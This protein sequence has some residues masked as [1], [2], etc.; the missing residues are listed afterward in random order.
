M[1]CPK[2]GIQN[3]D[4]GRFCR[5]CGTDLG[6]VSQALSGKLPTAP[7][8]RRNK[9]KSLESSITKIFTGI[10]FIVAA[11]VLGLTGVAG[12]KFWW[13]WL[14]IPAFGSLGSGV[15]EYI[16]HR[17]YE[18]SE[19]LPPAPERTQMAEDYRSPGLNS[20]PAAAELSSDPRYRTGDLV[21]PSVT[22]HTTKLLQLE[23]EGETRTLPPT[24]QR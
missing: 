2:C 21:P 1:F 5:S 19:E 10:A 12:G 11:A 4:N 20:A 22:D 13:F 3:P 18:A 16:S 7:A 14:L 23:H 15:A 9:A 8:N 17:R 24:D 6:T